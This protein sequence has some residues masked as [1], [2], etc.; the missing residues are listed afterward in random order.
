MTDDPALE[1]LS[2]P[3]ETG[4]VRWPGEAGVLF[5]RARYGAAV[6][7]WSRTAVHCEQSFKPHADALRHAGFRVEES[8]A[9]RNFGGVVLLPPRQRD[10]ARALLARAIQ[11]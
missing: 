2:L 11:R 1:T 3:F 8:T 5:L 7:S 10:E 6:E 9:D 4:A